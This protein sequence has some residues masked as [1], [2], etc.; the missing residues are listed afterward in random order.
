MSKIV[1]NAQGVEFNLSTNDFSF[2]QNE[3]K[4]FDRKL[5][6]KPTTFLKDAFRRFC[7]NKSSVVGAIIIGIIILMS[8]VVP[9]ATP[10]IGAYDV[11]APSHPSEETLKPKLFDAGTGFWDGTEEIS[12]IHAVQDD[13]G[14]WWPGAGTTYKREAMS[15]I[16]HYQDH[17]GNNF[18]SF[19]YD[20]YAALYGVVEKD[21][22]Q[23]DLMKY[24][25]QGW[26]DVEY[27]Q[28]IEVVDFPVEK[29]LLQSNE[30]KTQ[31]F[32]I[33]NSTDAENLTKYGKI[34]PKDIRD[35]SEN[36]N[37]NGEVVSVSFK[38]TRY[39]FTLTT[40]V[41]ECTFNNVDSV[42]YPNVLPEGIT[43]KSLYN[44]KEVYTDKLDENGNVV[45]D[46]HGNAVQELDSIL[47]D[48]VPFKILSEV[49]EECPVS[50]IYGFKV[51]VHTKKSTIIKAICKVE[52]YKSFGYTKA[53]KFI[54]GTD[55]LGRDLFT[56][57]FAGMMESLIFSLVITTIC[58]VFGLVWG[59]ISGYF[60]GNVD[61]IMERFMEILSGVPSVVIITLFRLHLM[62]GPE[63]TLWVFA[64]SLCVTGWM[65]TASRTRT[66]FYRF[67]GREY[68]LASRTLGSS[69]FRLIFK[70]ILPNA[71]GTIVTGAAL[72]IPGLIF[73]EASY[74]YL[75]L[76]L[77]G[78]SSFGAILADNQGALKTDPYLILFP[79]V[80]ISLLM[81]SF[82][83]FG[84]G[85]RDALNP[86]LKGS[87]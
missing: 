82:N 47:Y 6:T 76:G 87:E 72:M 27:G 59:S 70:H 33:P 28:E 23:L 14:N 56:R 16:K 64:L 77:Q 12:G 39:A 55:Q 65:G 13:E 62:K 26:I 73:T 11:S 17:E 66:Q 54:F 42:W 71:M 51:T 21:I 35:Y 57:C 67:K 53:P 15:N 24:I 29:C 45:K 81:I 50:E 19:T 49:A 84:N 61:L 37:S 20:S 46:E 69:D 7:K 30:D 83:L 79:S 22:D 2:V 85:L 5:E 3:H 48:Y 75:G 58:F 63:D 34:F 9:I 4:I 32:Y 25:S 80:I 40:P 41:E 78:G 8:I 52:N 31:K 43:V 36:K 60:G 44:Y 74:A 10:K 18:V 38:Y 68:I 1:K 86:S